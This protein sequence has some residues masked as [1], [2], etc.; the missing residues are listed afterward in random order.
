M[1]KF[2]I[3]FQPKN[4]KKIAQFV[5]VVHLS[6]GQNFPSDGARLEIQ[7]ETWYNKETAVMR[8]SWEDNIIAWVGYSEWSRRARYIFFFQRIFSAFENDVPL[9][10]WFGQVK[11]SPL[12][13]REIS[14]SRGTRISKNFEYLLQYPT[15]YF[16]ERMRSSPTRR[17]GR[18]DWN[19]T[20][21]EFLRSNCT[22]F[23]NN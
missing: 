17:N 4:L 16:D 14:S 11:S 9:I 1:Q 2:K 6:F 23:P 15:D 22:T 13:F 20:R 18:I 19:F 3:F 12:I 7:V 5:I 10:S 21:L 8:K